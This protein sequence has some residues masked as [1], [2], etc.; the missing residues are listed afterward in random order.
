MKNKS[1][2]FSGHRQIPEE[3][4]E[5]IYQKLLQT[6]KYLSDNGYTE[7]YAG[8]AYGFDMM[9]ELAV[10]QTKRIFPDIHLHLV[11]PFRGH[12]RAWQDSDRRVFAKILQKA[13][14]AEFLYPKYT[15]W[16]YA[17]RNKKMVDKSSVLVYYLTKQTGGTR[18]TLSYASANDL[19]LIDIAN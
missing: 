9:A 6:V 13:D 14:S 16:S 1:V 15:R 3:D 17:E 11:I 4:Y 7:F 18:H 10:L 19:R 2:C 8:G 5:M 12:D